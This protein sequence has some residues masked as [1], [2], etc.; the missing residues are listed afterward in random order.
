MMISAELLNILIV[1]DDE[2]DFYIIKQIL[3]SLPYEITVEWCYSYD[4][5]LDL[6][7][8]GK[9]N[10]YLVDFRL[11]KKTGLD[12]FS[13]V[14]TEG[15]NAPFIL[16]TGMGN[17]DI[18]IQAMKAGVTDYLVKDEINPEKMERSIRYALERNRTLSE[19]KENENKFRTIFENSK[20]V[21]FLTNDRGFIKEINQAGKELLVQLKDP[22]HKWNLVQSIKGETDKEKIQKIFELHGYAKDW[23]IELFSLNAGIRNCLLSIFPAP[24][25]QGDFQG[26]LHDITE[27]KKKEKNSFQIEKLQAAGRFIR[28]LAHEVRNPLN[29][30]NLALEEIQEQNTKDEL[31]FFID[32]INRNSGRINALITELLHSLRNTEFTMGMCDLKATLDESLQSAKDAQSL[33]EIQINKIY[34]EETLYLFADRGKLASAF[35]NLIQNAIDAVEVKR[36]VID[37]IC[38]R[39]NG[40][41]RVIIQDNGCGIAEENII[42]LFEPYFTTKRNGMGLGMLAS[43]NIIQA[44][45]GTIEVY[46]ELGKGSSFHIF[47]NI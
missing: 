22:D 34:P 40:Q 14:H 47:F 37:I 21:I 42:K 43:L 32:I 13:D 15:F 25:N 27:R 20:D 29:N 35:L 38:E 26:I 30:I 23:E 11:G 17:T 31:V 2:D 44:H 24:N 33:R 7:G 8:S 39:I 1:E 36:G 19:L 3:Q 9:F 16:L 46:S 45:N 6:I 12:L 4:K 5:A 28:T 18:A 41:I 10:F